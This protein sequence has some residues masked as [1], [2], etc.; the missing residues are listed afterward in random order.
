VPSLSGQVGYAV[1]LVASRL[2]S[3]AW[4][5]DC[6][7]DRRPLRPS[8]PWNQLSRISRSEVLLHWQLAELYGLT[9]QYGMD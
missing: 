7:N 8:N 5:N 2:A 9:E 3:H 1:G 6:E 4:W